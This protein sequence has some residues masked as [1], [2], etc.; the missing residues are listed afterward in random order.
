M[1][2]SLRLSRR[3]VLDIQQI[4]TYSV[5]KWGAK[6]AAEY[7]KSIEAALNLL[8]EDPSLLRAK[9]EFSPSL[10]FYRVRQHFLVCATF[11]DQIF[12]LTVKHGAMDLPN[13]IAEI[14]P[15]L[16]REAAMLHAAYQKKRRPGAG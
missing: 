15:Q 7:L 14:E 11:E 12:V 9:P 10:S 1:K 4:E 5:E 13:R 8:R 6:V 3:A 16:H 2:V